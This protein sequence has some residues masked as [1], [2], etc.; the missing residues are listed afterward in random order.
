MLVEIKNI[1][2][3]DDIDTTIFEKNNINNVDDLSAY[4]KT[5]PLLD[6]VKAIYYL[7]AS[8]ISIKPYQEYL[9]DNHVPILKL[10]KELNRS[11]EP[12][13]TKRELLIEKLY[14]DVYNNDIK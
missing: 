13:P 11:T 9:A 1:V 8:D 3:K 14:D 7:I 12:D 2:L 10:I 6:R 4:I 5:V